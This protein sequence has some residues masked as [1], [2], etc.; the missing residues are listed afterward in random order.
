MASL[1][2]S[3][4]PTGAT[5]DDQSVE[6]Q[7]KS[8]GSNRES[9]TY[10]AY[11]TASASISDRP[12]S[13]PQPQ[14]QPQRGSNDGYFRPPKNHHPKQLHTIPK[15][16]AAKSRKTFSCTMGCSES[17]TRHHDRLRH[18]VSQ[19]G[20]QCDF[21]CTRCDRFFSSQRML[22]RHTCWSARIGPWRWQLKGGFVFVWV[23]GSGDLTVI[24]FKTAA[25]PTLKRELEGWSVPSP[26]GSCGPM[27]GTRIG[28]A[29]DR[30]LVL[31]RRPCIARVMLPV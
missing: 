15:T 9:S 19:H 23:G 12:V 17:F 10:D 11:P 1:A 16:H 24:F 7:A 6:P 28:G 26:I 3:W 14:S 25:M 29:P 2:S 5:Q 4:I 30:V 13:D 8:S 18:E 27:A 20:K 22:D 21:A 31:V